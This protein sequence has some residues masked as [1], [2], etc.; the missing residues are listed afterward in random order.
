MAKLKPYEIKVTGYV[1][2][3]FT[4]KVGVDAC[5]YETACDFAKECVEEGDY[6]ASIISSIK[7]NED[8]EVY[9]VQA[10]RLD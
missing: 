2:I 6:D 9:D 1:K 5:D 4:V 3:P 10:D 7:K 8:I